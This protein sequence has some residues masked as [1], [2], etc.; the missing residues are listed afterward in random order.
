MNFL[1]KIL[2]PFD[3]NNN[4]NRDYKDLSKESQRVTPNPPSDLL[5]YARDIAGHSIQ[6]K[7]NL[8]P[9][10][11]WFRSE[12]IYPAFDSMNFTYNNHIF[13]VIIDIKDENGVSYL[14]EEF[15]KRQLYAE[16]T[17]NVIPCKYTVTVP[18][19]QEPDLNQVKPV[20]NDWNLIHTETEEP[21]FPETYDLVTDVEMSDWEIRNYG[22]KFVMKY[23]KAKRYKIR[24]YQDTLEVDPQIWF[25]DENG[26]RCWVM[27]RCAKPPQ[28]EI[29]QPKKI[30]EIVRR[31][32]KY[33]GYFA[34]VILTPKD[35]TADKLYRGKDIRIDFKGFAKIHDAI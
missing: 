12:Y 21:I 35:R 5:L 16:K 29:E 18:N 11:M 15:K 20:S 27:V 28:N 34:G 25:T 22:I 1:K 2:N 3:G 9:N 33:D 8:L 14:P 19:P 24:T 30:K 4:K 10:C 31:C 26:K 6:E 23:L 13:S 17:Y 32:F 7:I